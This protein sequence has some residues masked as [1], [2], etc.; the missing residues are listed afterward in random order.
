MSRQTPLQEKHKIEFDLAPVQHARNGTITTVQCLFCVHIRREKRDGPAIK[1]QH[2]KNPAIVYDIVGNPFFNPKEDEED[3]DSE[4][5]TKANAMKL[6]KLQED[7]LYLVI[8]KNSLRFNLAIE[9]V[10]VGLSFRQL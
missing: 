4:P 3:D 1:R 8:I 2:T 5:I 10:S 9:H 6:F 7:R